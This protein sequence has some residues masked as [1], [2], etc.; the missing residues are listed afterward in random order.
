[1]TEPLPIDVF[2]DVVCPWCLLGNARLERVLATIDHPVTVHYRPFLLDPDTP[3]EGTD[4]PAMLTRKYGPDFR[5]IWTRLEDEAHKAGIQLDLGKQ[6]WSFPTE[7]AHTLIRHGAERGTQRAL[8]RS[9]FHANFLEARN[10]SDPAVLVEIARPHGFADDEV[11][12][13]LS[14]PDELGATRAEAEQAI[15]MGVRGVPLFVFGDGLALSGAQPE[16]IIRSAILRAV[17]G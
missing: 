7:R 11:A 14:N 6:R 17:A 8:V 12:R 15:A 5:R 3:P 9:L 16:E 4:I 1:M 10:I 2:V 13:L